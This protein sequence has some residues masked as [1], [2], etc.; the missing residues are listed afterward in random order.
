MTAK[1]VFLYLWQLPQNLLGLCLLALGHD[2]AFNYKGARVYSC[3][4][5]KGGISLGRYIFLHFPTSVDV[6]H[7]YGHTRQ[8]RILGPLYLPVVGLWSATRAAFNL[9]HPGHYFDS[10]PENW[11][12]RLG[13]VYIDIDGKRKASL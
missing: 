12:D 1:Q 11:A 4:W 8:S 13:G 6:C 10:F 2:E 9:Y 5:M 7:E 3:T